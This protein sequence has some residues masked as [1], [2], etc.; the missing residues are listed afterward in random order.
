MTRAEL[1]ASLQARAAEAERIGALAP[2]AAVLRDL[3]ATVEQV[4]GW[5]TSGPDRL[6]SLED[7]AQQ[8]KV[9]V[10][11][12]REARPPYVVQLG[13]KTFRVS[14]QKLSRWLEHVG[15]GRV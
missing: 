6:L 11:W 5:P 12:L 8:L 1:V 7:A 14:A 4:D 2:V 15:D 9:S 13:D 10:R 3:L